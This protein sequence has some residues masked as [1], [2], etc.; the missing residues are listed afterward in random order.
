MATRKNTPPAAEG[1]AARPSLADRLNFA[2]EATYKLDTLISRLDAEIDDRNNGGI[3]CRGEIAVGKL[4]VGRCRALTDA[5]VGICDPDSYSDPD[6][7]RS[8]FNSCAATVM[9]IFG[10][11]PTPE[12]AASP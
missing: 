9:S 4:L 1:D 12:S 6:Q 5:L 3:A 10:E 7:D 2:L 11:A 8:E